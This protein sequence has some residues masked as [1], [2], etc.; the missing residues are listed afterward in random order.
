MKER[1][2]R[3]KR[4]TEKKERKVKVNAKK[5]KGAILSN[6]NIGRKYGL[7]LLV[8]FI[9]FGSSTV[10]VG[11]FISDIGRNM[12]E[13]ERRGDRALHI[14]KM[15]TL[16][17]GMGQR[18]ANYV[19]YS[20]QSYADEFFYQ[21]ET[22]T[23]IAEEVGTKLRTPEQKDL[24]AIVVTNTQT[25]NAAFS[26]QIV[27]AV[28]DVDFVT[29]KRTASDMNNLQ[30]ESVMILETLEDIINEER[31]LAVQEAN[32]SQEA[33]FSV[34]I[35]SMVMTVLIGSVL[36]FIISRIISKNLKTVVDV[37]NEI[38]TG[39]L[40]VQT[41]N[42]QGKDE[43]G[44][45]AL[46]INTMS[47]NL[48]NMIQQILT[49]SESVNQQSEGLKNS[50]FEV[51][52]GSAQVAVT[53]QEL[54]SGTESLANH[55]NEL[56]STM[57]Q[58]TD[59]V[60]GV[61]ESGANINEKS[62]IVLD[63]TDKGKKLMESSISQMSNIDQIMKAAVQK[64]E[65]LDD[66]SK[67]I[68]K[69]V[70]VIKDIAD[71]TNLL[72]L[73]AAIEA[74][75]AGEHGKGFAVVAG[76]VRKLSEQV[77]TSVKDITTIVKNI[78]NE[79][80]TVTGSLKMGYN[81]VLEGTTQIK[82]TGETFNGISNAVSQMVE[83]IQTVTSNLLTISSTSQIMSSSIQEVA[84]ISEES[85]AGVQESSAT[86]EQISTTIE[87]VAKNTEE[88]SLLSRKLNEMVKGFTL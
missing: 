23:L 55:V 86:T 72:A 77:S 50:S 35:I 21:M 71:Q 33:T 52:E 13:L 42:Y 32:E 19:H 28:R 14:A 31:Q 68:T 65:G 41:I 36:V 22:F 73:N 38:A 30:L 85:A 63:M 78:Q 51:K 53:M 9:L 18:I 62:G 25:I 39:N 54:S 10:L 11:N 40:S 58:F 37:S 76:E 1:L 5:R 46:A 4:N 17:Q 24:L 79:T 64:V 3:G 27:P 29:A 47:Q 48:R 45:I 49:I 70:S 74:A 75:R 20:T 61:N 44:Q 12:D 82:N 83:N 88:L 87:Q 67:Q 66:Q 7:T 56:S 26:E 81:E 59:E 34:L 43:I 80:E 69:L 6:M 2:K 8:I 84:S 57:V 16:T 15:N 60:S